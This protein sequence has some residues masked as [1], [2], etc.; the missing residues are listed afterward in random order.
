MNMY[1]CIHVRC[2][3][4]SH[5]VLFAAGLGGGGLGLNTQTPYDSHI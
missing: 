3:S 2:G 4:A 5:F 1:T